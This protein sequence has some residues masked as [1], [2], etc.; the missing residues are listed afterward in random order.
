MHRRDEKRG[1]DSRR[2]KRVKRGQ[3]TD[4]ERTAKPDRGGDRR[5]EVGQKRM[6][7]EKDAWKTEGR[8]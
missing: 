2:T 3:R 5:K 8:R 1:G 7:K 6:R 4:K